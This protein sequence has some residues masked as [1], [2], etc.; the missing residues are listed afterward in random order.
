MRMLRRSA[1]RAGH[2]AGRERLEER[3]NEVRNQSAQTK[4]R[5]YQGRLFVCSLHLTAEAQVNRRKV[6]LARSKAAVNR[7]EK[8]GFVHPHDAGISPPGQPDARNRPS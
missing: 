2:M 3:Y 4:R 1:P 7:Q 6:R 8:T 5:L